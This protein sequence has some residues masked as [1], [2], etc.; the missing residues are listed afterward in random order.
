[1][2]RPPLV[3]ICHSDH[4]TPPFRRLSHTRI[5]VVIRCLFHTDKTATFIG[6][7]CCSGMWCQPFTWGG[8]YCHGLLFEQSSAPSVPSNGFHLSKYANAHLSTGVGGLVMVY[9]IICINDNG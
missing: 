5:A 1:M 7:R 9:F 2:C 4:R 6:K 3:L 8:E